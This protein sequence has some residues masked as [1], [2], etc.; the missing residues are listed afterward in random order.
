MEAWQQLLADKVELQ[1]EMSDLKADFKSVTK[2]ASDGPLAL[3]FANL[4]AVVGLSASDFYLF[5]VLI[6]VLSLDKGPS[7]SK[8]L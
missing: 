5:L 7:G 6:A 4:A 3:Y 1:Q 8:V 2:V